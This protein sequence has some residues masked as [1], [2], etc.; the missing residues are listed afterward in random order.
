M[1]NKI[2]PIHLFIKLR[3]MEISK[4]NVE[5][6]YQ[7]FYNDWC[8]FQSADVEVD[9]EPINLGKDERPTDNNLWNRYFN[10][11]RKRRRDENGLIIGKEFVINKFEND[12]GTPL[13]EERYIES[14]KKKFQDYLF[15]VKDDT[16]YDDYAYRLKILLDYMEQREK[17]LSKPSQSTEMKGFD[18]KLSDKQ[19]RAIVPYLKLAELFE[20]SIDEPILKKLFD[21]SLESPL[22]LNNTRLLAYF[23][24]ELEERKLITMRWQS[25]AEQTKSFLS[26][27]GNEINKGD[28]SQ[29]LMRLKKNGNPKGSEHIDSAI[30]LL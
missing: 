3:L 30:K 18:S 9:G 4:D 8:Y 5:E 12:R 7:Y 14:M 1:N 29:A 21:G 23:F 17:E 2:K 20:K 25:A 16:K 28:L 10:R 27:K 6:N 19:I 15:E 24:N 26:V 13:T 11:H 22:K